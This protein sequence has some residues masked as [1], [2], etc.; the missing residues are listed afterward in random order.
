MFENVRQKVRN[1]S[2]FALFAADEQTLFELQTSQTMCDCFNRFIEKCVT[3]H[4]SR[5]RYPPSD[6]HPPLFGS[7]W[8]PLPLSPLYIPLPLRHLPLSTA[9]NRAL[10]LFTRCSKNKAL[11]SIWLAEIIKFVRSVTKPS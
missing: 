7:S 4:P 11:R 8:Q 1:W 3:S 5:S 6:P 9:E 2:L 10:R